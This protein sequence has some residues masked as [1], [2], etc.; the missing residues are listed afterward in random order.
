MQKDGSPGSAGITA[1][2]PMILTRETIE[3]LFNYNSP[4]ARQITTLGLRRPL[5]KGWIDTLIGKE[6]S[7]ALYA[8]LMD[9]K[10]RRP[11]GLPRREWRKPCIPCE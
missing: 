10:G 11:S 3:A 6:I 2:R 7:D 9:C 4:N 8:E 1:N 5:K